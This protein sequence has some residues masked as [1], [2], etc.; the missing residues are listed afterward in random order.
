MF[1]LDTLQVCIH[2]LI[3]FLAK[4]VKTGGEGEKSP[5][6]EVKTSP[7]GKCKQYVGGVVKYPFCKQTELVVQCSTVKHCYHLGVRRLS[8]VYFSHF[9]L[10]L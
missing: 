7:L 6:I 3:F 5:M 1:I 4:L 10:H 9:N 2:I 8:S